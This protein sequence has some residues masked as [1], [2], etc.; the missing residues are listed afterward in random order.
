MKVYMDVW[1]GGGDVHIFAHRGASYTH[2]E[3]TISAF[4]AAVEAGAEGIELDVT[5]SKDEE[6]VVIHDATLERTTNGS[7]LV[8]EHTAEALAQ[9]DAGVW[10]S[11]EFKGEPLPFLGDVLEWMKANQLIINLELKGGMDRVYRLAERV[12]DEIVKSGV[13]AER[14]VLSSFFH[15]VLSDLRQKLPGSEVAPL[16]VA[17]L[18]KPAFYLDVVGA[19]ALHANVLTITKDEARGLWKKG[20]QVR[21]FTI[22]D[23]TL[24]KEWFI[25]G[26]VSLMTDMPA[27]AVQIKQD[28]CKGK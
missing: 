9:L 4:N 18:Y 17:G 21:L 11:K 10:F 8:A 16:V 12:I 13:A 20:Y 25:E 24:L 27:E 22:N 6:V 15:P 28:L 5:L 14:F 23:P 2:P 26:T 1:G 7:G 3:N 19:D